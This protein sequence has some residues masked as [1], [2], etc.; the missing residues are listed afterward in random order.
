M[1]KCTKCKI[2]KDELEFHKDKYT[3]D[4]LTR[5]CKQ[6]VNRRGINKR[7]EQGIKPRRDVTVRRNGKKLCSKCKQWVLE[8]NFRPYT[9]NRDGLHV[10]CR[11]CQAQRTRAYDETHKE[12]RNKYFAD[13]REEINKQH[14]LY[15]LE[16][17]EK[18]LKQHRKYR[19]ANREEIN[20]KHRTKEYREKVNEQERKR[21]KANAGLR[22][23]RSLSNALRD[24]L[25]GRRKSA[26]TMELL[27]IDKYSCRSANP[28]GALL[29]HLEYQF[30]PG[31]TFSNIHIDHRIPISYAG[32]SLQ[33]EF[34]QRYLCNY[35]NL[36]PMFAKDNM[37]K[38]NRVKFIKN[39]ILK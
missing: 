10:E 25:T 32:D 9:H 12:Q 5:Q 17:R 16:N 6:C 8:S 30:K 34:W 22:L 26:P 36:Q 13:R 35:R 7:R 3:K 37:S 23:R 21:R 1:K 4:G 27:G 15:Y 20:Q 31:M 11:N 14:R 29:Q 2:E 19:D 18:C 39:K 38:G 24:H 33:E 28:L